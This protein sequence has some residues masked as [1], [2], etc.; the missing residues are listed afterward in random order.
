MGLTV[1]VSVALLFPG[2]GSVTPTGAAM[3]AV[4]ARLPNALTLSLHDA[5]PISFAPLGSVTLALMFPEPDAGPEPPPPEPAVDVAPRS[6]AGSRSV[7]VALLTFD[8]PTF[9][10]TTV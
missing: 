3:L 9:V 7:N 1:S 6:F 8:G 5:L 2:V 10:A 4:F